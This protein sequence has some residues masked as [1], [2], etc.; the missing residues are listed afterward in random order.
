MI[1]GPD[2]F[3]G[4]GCYPIL[5]L[6]T[7][8][9]KQEVLAHFGH[10]Y[11]TVELDESHFETIFRTAGEFIASYFPFEEKKAVFYTKPLV[12]QYD[13][14]KDAWWIKQVMWDP[15]VTRIGD[16]FGAESFLFNIGNITGIQNLLLDYHLLQSYRK[17]SQ[18]VLATEGR[19][20]VKGENKI[21]LIPI[22]R[23]TFPVFVEYFP[24]I[25]S[26]RS[27]WSKE[28]LKRML[29]AEASMILGNIRSKRALPTPDGGSTDFNGENLLTWGREEKRQ[30]IDDA[31]KMGEPPGIYPY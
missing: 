27:P 24:C 19:W 28:L 15:A 21:T 6:D 4:Q 11:V 31:M 3:A 29:I 25:S 9:T 23:G 7:N 14:P 1:C 30:V 26:F 12:N 5:K 16:I 17:F 13:L 18:R 8:P 20:E 2:G 10:P 22:P